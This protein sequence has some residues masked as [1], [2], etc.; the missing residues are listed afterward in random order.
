MSPLDPEIEQRIDG[1]VS[2]EAV[3]ETRMTPAEAIEGMRIRFP[4]R[5]NKK[6]RRVIDRANADPQLK[7]WW[8]VSN[9]NAVVR[10]QIN[11]P[12][13]KQSHLLIHRRKIRHAE[14]LPQA[15]F[16]ARTN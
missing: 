7:A 10:M 1:P 12:A 15:R 4:E 6:L 8:H 3:R 2:S 9:V 14:L 16:H 5:G 13:R 11:D